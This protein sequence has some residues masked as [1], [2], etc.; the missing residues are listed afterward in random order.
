MAPGESTTA[1][2]EPEPA[3]QAAVAVATPPE[4]ST[5]TATHGGR[6]RKP[7]LAGAAVLGAVL[8]AVPLIMIGSGRDQGPGDDG[9]RSAAVGAD[10]VLDPGATAPAAVDDYVAAT[11]SPSPSNVTP[12]APPK[13][14]TKPAPPTR[15]ASPSR[16]AERKATPKPKAAPKAA[17]KPKWSET[18]VSAP[19]VLEVNQAWT[20]NRIRLVMQTDG[21][22]VVYDENGNP[23]WAAMTFGQ[24]HR[25]I[26]QQDGNLVIHNGDDR[27]IWAS[28][29]HGHEG[30]RL[31]LRPDGKVVIIHNG[32]VIWST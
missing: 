9:R 18:S 5:A 1:A 26:F 14:V 25:A 22:L 7:V 19:S 6:P 24:N 23:R 13:P 30:A 27:P 28:R 11:P 10:T 12:S 17:P 32:Q 2:P 3:T 20:T 16:P 29:T 4:V 21:N 31:V 8:V 15:E